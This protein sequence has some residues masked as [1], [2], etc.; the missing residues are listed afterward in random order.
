MPSFAKPINTKTNF[1]RVICP[2]CWGAGWVFQYFKKSVYPNLS[3]NKFEGMT[4]LERKRER[5]TIV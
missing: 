3:K 4:Q 1:K 5:P 2:R